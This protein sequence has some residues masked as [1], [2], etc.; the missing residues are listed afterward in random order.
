VAE[1]AV[2]VEV[3]ERLQLFEQ[4]EVEVLAEID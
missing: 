4:V 2:G 1:V 3:V